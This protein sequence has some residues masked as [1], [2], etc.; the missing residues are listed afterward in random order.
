MSNITIHRCPHD[1]KNP[2]VMINNNLIRNENLSPQCRWLLIYLLSNEEGWNISIQQLRNHLKKFAGRDKIYN[3]INEAIE[4]GYMELQEYLDGG[5]KRTRYVIS[6]TPKFKKCLPHP[7]NP[8]P[9]VPH[10]EASPIYKN[11]QSKNDQKK[12][13]ISELPFGCVASSFFHKLKAANPKVGKANLKKWGKELELLSKDGDG[14]T[15]E[16]IEKAIDYVLATASKPS[17]NGFSWSTVIQ[18][19]TSLRKNFPKIWAE[20]NLIKTVKNEPVKNKELANAIGKKFPRNDIV[21]GPD[22][23]EF[24]NGMYSTHV[25]F[26]DKEFK[27]KCLS[28]LNKRNL[29]IEKL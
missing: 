20:M 4:A 14:N 1:E 6:E 17:T 15:A 13:N 19:P 9:A 3:M 5:L 26:E 11:N 23:I 16:E 29:K 12:E 25:K 21:T 10:P 18:S 24:I 8:D 27:Q 7:E 28:E 22:Y 2:Y